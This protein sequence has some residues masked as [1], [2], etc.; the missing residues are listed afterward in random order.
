MTRCADTPERSILNQ[1]LLHIKPWCRW[2]VSVTFINQQRL[3]RSSLSLTFLRPPPGSVCERP[4]RPDAGSQLRVSA[5]PCDL[6]SPPSWTGRW[7]A[8]R[9]PGGGEQR[10]EFTQSTTEGW[11]HVQGEQTLT[12]P[13]VRMDRKLESEDKKPMASVLGYSPSSRMYMF[14]VNWDPSCA[15]Q[16]TTNMQ[17][18]EW[19]HAKMLPRA[20]AFLTPHDFISTDDNHMTSIL[21]K[22]HLKFDKLQ[23]NQF[24][25]HSKSQ[26]FLFNK[27]W[28]L[29]SEDKSLIPDV[30]EEQ[31][32]TLFYMRTSYRRVLWKGQR[33]PKTGLW[34]LFTCQPAPYRTWVWSL[35]PELPRC[36]PDTPAVPG[37]AP[38]SR[39]GPV[40]HPNSLS[41]PAAHTNRD[42]SS[43]L[44]DAELHTNERYLE[45]CG[46]HA[47]LQNKQSC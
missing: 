1:N 8:E 45:F 3:K 33:F 26:S 20:A 23:P 32:Q 30:P 21:I 19:S 27:L 37:S 6:C 14:S 24:S 44:I 31:K 39:A 46:S 22:T 43:F 15:T 38:Q 9:T 25:T 13:A 18:I 11:R 17:Y 16:L 34:W 40:T 4:G 42:S 10:V 41:D 7:T 35:H 28:A 12:C 29:K 5:P 36:P 47:V 2:Q